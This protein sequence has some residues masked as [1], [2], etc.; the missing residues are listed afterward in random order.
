MKQRRHIKA[1]HRTAIP[2][3]SIASRLCGSFCEQ[4]E[5]ET[6]GVIT[7]AKVFTGKIAIPGDKLEEYSKLM[8]QAE[9]RIAHSLRPLATGDARRWVAKA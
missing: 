4:E 7:M 9:E 2:L 5:L 1:L 3:R 6:W 8:E